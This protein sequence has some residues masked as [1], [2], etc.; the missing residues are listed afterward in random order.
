MQCGAETDRRAQE[1]HRPEH[2]CRQQA[3]HRHLHSQALGRW[4]AALA[5]GPWSRQSEVLRGPPGTFGIP[6][7]S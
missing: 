6:Q 3:R 5:A 4:L 7:V 2:Q 1:A